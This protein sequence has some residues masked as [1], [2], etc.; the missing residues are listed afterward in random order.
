[1]AE[2]KTTEPSWKNAP[3][4]EVSL[5]EPKINVRYAENGTIY[6]TEEK[7]LPEIPDRII[8]PLMHFAKTVPDRLFLADRKGGGDWRRVTY[9]QALEK[10]RSLGQFLLDQGLSADRP[11]LILSGNDLEH[12]LLGLAAAYVG[13]PYAPV[14][15][16]YSNPNT[17]Y[18]RLREIV[19]PLNPGMIFAAEKDGFAG[20]IAAIAEK[21]TKLLFGDSENDDGIDYAKAERTPVTKAVDEAYKKVNKDTIVKFL[22]TSGSTGTPKA[23]INTN[24]MIAAGQVMIQETFLFLRDEPVVVLDWA[25]WNHTAGGNKVFYMVMFNGGTLYIDDGR[26]T[27]ADI[28]K[29]IRNLEDVSPTWYF[30]LPKGFE[31]L[32]DHMKTHP[33]FCK[34]FFKNLKML[35]YAGA[36]LSQHT[37]NTLEEQA[38]ATTGTRIL[39]GTGLGATET[40]PPALFCTWP[41][42]ESGNM[43]LPCSG[44]ELK[45]VP[46]DG[47]LDARVR[48]PNI[49]PGYYKNPKATEKAFDE[50][51]FYCFGD[52][53]KPVVPGDFSKGFLFDGRTAENFKLNTGT[54]VTTGILRDKVIDHFENAV[55]DVA[56]TGADR[57]FLGALIFPNFEVLKEIAGLPDAEPGVLVSNPEVRNFFQQKLNE[58]AAKSTGSSTLVRR[59]LLV[60]TP[61]SSVTN[62][63]T[64]KGSVNQ[65]AVLQN[66]A[67]L[68]EE[69]YKGS[70][71]LIEIRKA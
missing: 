68:V 1:M 20:A 21:D 63:V 41:Q 9:G 15:A 44:V 65:R 26:P 11:L 38:V 62:E 61:P 56:I 66:R 71:R 43:G 19:P 60:E 8:D 12:A 54:W 46:M 27:P 51:G 36:K 45:L 25:P 57:D 13:V 28:Y 2:I 58:M 34:K 50:E 6:I 52:A 70:P 48:G 64:D 31:M 40:S 33:D 7:P 22:F 24:G 49:M 14:S 39:I 32:L 4:R 18:K 37:W 23:V 16:A 17:E 53:L 30:N 3:L 5:W 35:W 29:T 59:I 42:E 67:D 10:I 69:I 47:K 55:K